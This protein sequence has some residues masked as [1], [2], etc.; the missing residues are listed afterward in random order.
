MA[1]SRVERIS[2]WIRC[3]FCNFL[4]ETS[5]PYQ[6]CGN[7]CIEYYLTPHFVIFDTDRNE[8]AFARAIQK[9][10]GLTFGSKTIDVHTS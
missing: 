8:F 3:P 1:K 7:C 4:V 10:G 9:G 2:N 6:W 5:G